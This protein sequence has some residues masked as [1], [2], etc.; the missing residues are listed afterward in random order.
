[1]AVGTPERILDAARR[2]LLA[3]GYARLSTRQ[4]AEDADLPLSQ[5]HYHFGSRRQLMLALLDRENARLLERQTRMFD[6]EVPLW[7][8]WEQACDFFE[9]DLASGYVRVLQEMMAAGWSDPE[10]ASA[11]RRDLR[12]WYELLTDVAERALDQLGGLGPFTPAEAAALAGNAFLGSEALI[13]LGVDERQV[14]SRAA[15]RRVA[16]L[17]RTAE[18]R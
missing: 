18:A 15:L 13:L 14:P 16:E 11:V 9:D 4:I 7:K 3:V 5:I 12:G 8:Q 10:V 6:D 17:I 2:S 1:M